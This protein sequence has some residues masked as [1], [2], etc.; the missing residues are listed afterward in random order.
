MVG[1]PQKGLCG[2]APC[3]QHS[4]ACAVGAMFVSPVLQ[5]GVG[6][7]TIRP[8]SRRDDAHAP[9]AAKVAARRMQK[10]KSRATSVNVKLLLPPRQSQRLSCL[11]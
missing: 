3:W 5:R 11:E 2:S 7:P 9:R 8:E 4:V 6:K 10:R 1:A